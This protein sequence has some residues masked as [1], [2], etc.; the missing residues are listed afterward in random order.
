MEDK[1]NYSTTL[2]EH[3]KIIANEIFKFSELRPGQLDAI[4]YFIEEEKNTLVIINT[5][6][7]KSFCYAT[8]LVIFDSLIVVI[9]LLKSLIQSQN[10]IKALQ[11]NLNITYFEIA[12]GFD[13]LCKDLYFSVQERDLA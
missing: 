7:G 10:N 9:L 8:A 3:T 12:K 6:N 5:G 4:K 1:A 11:D 2:N 13:L